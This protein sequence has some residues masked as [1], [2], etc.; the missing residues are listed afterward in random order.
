MIVCKYV[1]CKDKIN[2][3]TKIENK[4]FHKDAFLIVNNEKSPIFRLQ[5]L[6]PDL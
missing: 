2:F 5:H 4:L 1:Q 3:E 6:F